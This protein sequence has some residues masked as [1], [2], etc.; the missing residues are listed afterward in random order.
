MTA[1]SATTFDRGDIPS[2]RPTL[3]NPEDRFE[4]CDK[5]RAILDGC[6]HMLIVGGPGSG[7]TTI[8]LLKARRA[9]LEHLKP[10]QTVLFVS[11]S[12]AAIR[13][14]LESGRSLLS[15]EIERR[16][17]IKTYHSFAWEILRSH[18][19]LLSSQRRLK[20]VGAQD[21]AVL[22]AGLKEPDWCAEQA[23]LFLEDGRATYDQFAPRAAELLERSRVVRKCFSHAHPLILVDEFQ[24]TDEDQWRLIRALARDSEI[25]ALGD[26]EQRIYAWRRGMSATRLQEYA[27]TLDARLF[28]FHDENKRSP[29]TGIAGY[30]RSLLF[31]GAQAELPGDILTTHFLPGR[32]AIGLRFALRATWKNGAQR[33]GGSAPSIAVA[34]RSRAMVRH[35]SDSLSS[36]LKV[37]GKQLGPIPH[38]VM[39]DQM[40]IAL[41]ARVIAFLLA[42]PGLPRREILSGAL[43]RVG[44]VQRST[45]TK[46]GITTSARL[47]KWAKRVRAGTTPKTKF[48]GSLESV[49]SEIRNEGLV[50]SPTEDWLNVRRV[51]EGADA[52]ELRQTGEHAKYLRLLRPGSAIE[53]EL[54][55]L[56]RRGGT[57][58]GAE[59]ALDDAILQDQLRDNHRASSQLSVMTMHQLKAREF[60]AVLLVEDRYRTFRG[61][62]GVPPYME[63]RRLLQVSLTRARHFACILSEKDS[64]TLE[65][66]LTS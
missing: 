17:E 51:L 64:A 45:G 9:A 53:E 10:A 32:F 52:K 1:N 61:K 58:E 5:R 35:I 66:I 27:K 38:D 50:G 33:V 16:I 28:D 65:L 39:C 56:W 30:A 31:P 2:P 34:A 46:T 43:E 11:F 57:Y 15:R 14:I 29:A 26:A 7:K 25:I 44:S 19:Y 24:D 4:I 12:N 42:S 20:V 63:T 59:A 62:D 60:D 18:G 21:A 47:S 40:Q 8:G 13:R 55:T 23:R 41:A 6:G 3:D 54:A 22:G 36:P 48:L 37:R 49:L